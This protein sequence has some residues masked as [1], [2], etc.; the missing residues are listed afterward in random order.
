MSWGKH[1]PHL[2]KKMERC[3]DSSWP[4]DGPLTQSDGPC[5]GR[6]QRGVAW[7]AGAGL[8]SVWQLLGAGVLLTRLEV[9]VVC[10]VPS[11]VIVSGSASE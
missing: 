1:L 3:L 7:S 9:T 5:H 10:P 4:L 2:D 8:G 6:G 11:M